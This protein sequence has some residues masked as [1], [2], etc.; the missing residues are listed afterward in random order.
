MLS[1]FLYN[2]A[3]PKEPYDSTGLVLAKYNND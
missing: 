1:C 2:E 3:S